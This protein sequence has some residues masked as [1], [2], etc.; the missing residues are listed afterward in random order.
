MAL[1][2]VNNKKKITTSMMNNAGVK[3]AKGEYFVFL[4]NNV[5][6]SD[7]WLDELLYAYQNLPQ[8]GIVSGRLI[9]PAMPKDNKIVAIVSV[10]KVQE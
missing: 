4:D 9:Y 5:I 10:F 7:R 1:T 6:V 3:K 8:A 2:V